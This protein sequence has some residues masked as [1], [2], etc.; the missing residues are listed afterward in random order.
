[1][2]FFHDIAALKW[3]LHD[4]TTTLWMEKKT[5]HQ[6]A[7][8]S[9]SQMGKWVS[10]LFFFYFACQ[11]SLSRKL[12]QGEQSNCKTWLPVRFF[13]FYHAVS[14]KAGKNA[15]SVKLFIHLSASISCDLTLYSYLSN[16]HREIMSREAT[17]FQTIVTIKA[18]DNLIVMS[19]YH[20]CNTI[21]CNNWSVL[22]SRSPES[23]FQRGYVPQNG[24]LTKALWE[25]EKS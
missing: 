1:M 16:M 15:T 8:T 20:W 18:I 4:V 5:Q 14:Q 25:K 11:E 7:E 19:R 17:G 2:C 21:P 6:L 24:I 3:V 23:E 22:A 9:K 12:Q 13:F 10:A